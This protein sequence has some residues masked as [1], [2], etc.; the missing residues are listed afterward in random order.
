M[1]S[2]RAVALGLTLALGPLATVASADDHGLEQVLVESADTPAEHQALA[3]HYKHLAEKAKSEAAAHRAMA[4]SYGGVKYASAKA[5]SDHCDKLASL[6]DQEAAQY[7]SL[8]AAHEAA[9][10]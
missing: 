7:D 1:T 10:K 3:K 8:A 6:A 4:K 2:F 5:M 9:A